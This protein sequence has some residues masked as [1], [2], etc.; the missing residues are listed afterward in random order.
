MGIAVGNAKT[1]TAAAA[2]SGS[3]IYA[4]DDPAGRR[5]AHPGAVMIGRKGGVE[6]R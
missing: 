5:H 6:R 3:I 1:L 2:A 4:A